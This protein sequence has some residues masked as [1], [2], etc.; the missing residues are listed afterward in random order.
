MNHYKKFA[1]PVA[2]KAGNIMR[3]N[4][5]IGMAKEWKQDN[6]P[7]TATDLAINDL[8]L[9]EVGKSFP[10][11]G[12]LAEEGSRF[13]NEEYVWV[14]DPVDG[15]TPFSHGYPTFTFSLALVKNGYPILGLIYDPILDRLVTAE[16]GQGAY[17]NGRTKI[18]VNGSP[19]FNRS[20]VA[21]EAD[22]AKLRSELLNK[23]CLVTTF[24]CIT[25]PSLLVAIGEFKAAIW[26]G[27]SPWDG[28][29]AQIIVE[30]AGGICTDIRGSKQRYDGPVN[31]IIASNKLVHPILVEMIKFSVTS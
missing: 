27:K 22:M 21:L 18:K 5:K 30:E 14:C 16:S 9:S 29:A 26:H 10:D 1:I 8:V 31:G 20:I 23:K 13:N 3:H 6:S 11:H 12:I 7:L 28:V 2:L 15:T 4:F 19:E 17:L 24:A 25:Y